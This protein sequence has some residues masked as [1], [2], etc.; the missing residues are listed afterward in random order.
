MQC[1][2]V[3]QRSTGP[4]L[5]RAGAAGPVQHAVHPSGGHPHHHLHRARLVWSVQCQTEV[6]VSLGRLVAA[7]IST[8][9][10][11]ALARHLLPVPISPLHHLCL[12]VPSVRLIH[13]AIDVLNQQTFLQQGPLGLV[14]P[15]VAG[16]SRPKA[17]RG[18][19]RTQIKILVCHDSSH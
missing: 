5:R 3:V 17:G 16:N 10:P 13:A 12:N 11:R 19:D 8:L 9:G 14:P 7:V 1:N 4:V 6:H 15:A 18:G 2:A